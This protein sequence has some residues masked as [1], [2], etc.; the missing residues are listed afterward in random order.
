M[1]GLGDD[2]GSEMV[3]QFQNENL[4]AIKDG[5]IVCSVPD[6]ISILDADT[7][8]PITTEYLRYGYRVIA[9]GMPIHDKWRTP[10]GLKVIGPRY[11]GYDINYVPIEERM[12]SGR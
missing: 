7:G 12:R 1:E 10:E 9:I 5:D 8:L 4:V 6:L 11:F 3:V 2:S